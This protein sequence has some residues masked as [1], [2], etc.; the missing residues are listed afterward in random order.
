MHP[1]FVQYPVFL[2]YRLNGEER[3]L[4]EYFLYPLKTSGLKILK[5]PYFA[6][7]SSGICYYPDLNE[8]SFKTVMEWMHPVIIF[9]GNAIQE[10]PE[11][12]YQEL[13]NNGAA[14]VWRFPEKGDVIFPPQL[15]LPEIANQAYCISDNAGYRKIFRQILRFGGY[16]TRVDFQTNAGLE[17]ELK[18]L[19]QSGEGIWPSLLLVDLDSERIDVI[20]F[21]YQLRSL[22]QKTPSLRSKTSLLA[23]KD[24]AKPGLDLRVIASSLKPLTKRIFHPHEAILAAS[25]AI[26]ASS[27]K[28]KTEEIRIRPFRTLEEMLYGRSSEFP[29]ENPGEHIKSLLKKGSDLSRFTLFSWLGEYLKSQEISSGVILSP[30]PVIDPG[31]FLNGIRRP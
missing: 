4:V 16:N 8:S 22:F 24:F 27:K 19:S 30:D 14:A 20:S 26:C 5:D 18:H 2:G 9:A 13:F 28:N 1:C 7:I 25:E 21:F 3:L 17:T 12:Y 10:K 6:D 23:M 11:Q 31:N 15:N 29:G